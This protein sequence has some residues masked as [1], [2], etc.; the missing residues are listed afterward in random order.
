M[1]RNYN[2]GSRNMAD[3][4]RMIV[5][6]RSHNGYQTKR[7]LAERWKIFSKWATNQGVKKM[8]NVTREL[9]IEY[10]QYQQ[11]LIDAG[12]RQG[13]S[14]AKNYVSAVNSV[15]RLATKGQWQS[16]YPGQ[17]CGIQKRRYLPTEN[18]AMSETW[19]RNAQQE[20]GERIACMLELQRKFGLRFKESALLNAAGALKEAHLRGYITVKA[21]TKGGRIRRVACRP[22]NIAALEKAA[23]VQNGRSMIPETMSYIEFR[24]ACYAQA[25]TAG[26]RF[27]SERHHYAQERYREITGAPAPI[28]AGWGRKQRIQRLAEHLQITE[29]DAVKIDNDARLRVSKELGHGRVEVANAY[30]G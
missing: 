4:G 18:K 19:H 27:H 7:D 2:A 26:V 29:E 15:M 11:R 17:D 16:V 1:S 5:N 28:A 6:A 25:H 14:T 24:R 22:D 10:G 8:E 23:A 9:V 13:A 3:A 12:E 21:G 20:L 30:L